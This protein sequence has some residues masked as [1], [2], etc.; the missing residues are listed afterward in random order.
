MRIPTKAALSAWVLA[1]AAARAGQISGVGP[2][3]MDPTAPPCGN[4]YQYADGGWLKA[5][6]IPS[7]FPSWGAFDE[8]QQRNDESQR[9]I[10]ESLASAS[11]TSAPDS[12]ER[13][14]GDFYAACMD[15]KAID[16]AGI[17][18]L[19]PE[20]ERIDRIASLSDLQSEI[21]RLQ[22]SGANA[23]FA[24]GSEQD[25]KK[26]TEVIAAAFQGGLGLPD[27]DYYLKSDDASK[28]M[29]AK[30]T[31]HVEKMFALAGDAPPKARADART[32]LAFE[33]RLAE[34]S[35]DRVERRDSDKTYNKTDAAGLAALTPNFSWPAYF[36]DLGAPPSPV[37]VGQPKFFQ[38][39]SKLLRQTPLPDW[40]VYLRWKLDRIRRAV[41]LCAVRRREL[42]LQRP[43][44]SGHAQEISRA[45]SAASR[46]PTGRWAWRSGTSGSASTSRRSRRSAPTRWCGLMIAALRDDL[47]DAAL[48]ERRDA[49]GGAAQAP[50]L[51]SE[52][53]LPRQVAR[54]LEP[55]GRTAASYVRER[56]GRD[57]VR[58]P[59]GPGEDRQ[60]RRPHRLGHDA[61]DRQRYYNPL[62]NE[63]VFP[64]R[65]PAAAVLRRTGR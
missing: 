51:R 26:S 47:R 48:D 41:A 18:P 43:D 64:G 40:K 49:P 37:N 15:E 56:D 13:K 38:A 7:D 57:G 34:A 59:P 55:E 3:N 61:A 1:A 5:N 22:L 60:A 8:L 58:V 23:V 36:R 25:R 10:L 35:M 14:L 52:D 27:R 44:P 50:T 6:P 32:V 65:H 12:D 29:R 28:Q 30:Y 2:A 21:A 63:I 39:V 20:L 53:R 45:G 19:K 9:Q 4:F 24:F 62:K 46:P 33:T 31:A 54:L 16:A 11:A 17:E 42:R